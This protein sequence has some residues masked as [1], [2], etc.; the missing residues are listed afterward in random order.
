METTIKLKRCMQLCS[1]KEYCKYDILQKLKLWKVEVEEGRK[2]IQKLEEDGF[3]DET[4]YAKAFVNDKFRFNH[5]GKIKIKYYLKQKNIAESII[6]ISL[7]NIIAE[8]YKTVLM[9]EI[10]KKWKAVKTES[11]F[12]KKQKVFNYLVSK[13][14]EVDLIM[15]LLP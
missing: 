7:E 13:G 8:E 5:W 6:R 4:R 14:F 10:N 3:I 1:K 12:E 11:N 2:I 15:D 9:N